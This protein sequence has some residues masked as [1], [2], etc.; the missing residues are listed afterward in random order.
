MV[1]STMHICEERA[2]D[3]SGCEA[4]LCIFAIPIFP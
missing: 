4:M 3:Y 1:A 2:K